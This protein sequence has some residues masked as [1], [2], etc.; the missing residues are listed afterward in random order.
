MTDTQADGGARDVPSRFSVDFAGQTLLSTYRVERKLAE[1][2][3]GTVYLGEDTNLGRQVV[4]KVPHARFLGEPGFRAR[5]KREVTELV[6][7]EHPNICRILAQGDNEELPYF[8]L[9]YLGGGSL[10]ERLKAAGGSVS[11]HDALPWLRTIAKTLDFIHARGIIHRDVKP[12]NV[13]LSKFGEVKL[14]DFGIARTQQSDLTETGIGLGT[15]SY[16]SPEQI[17]G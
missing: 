4:V 1:G 7:L 5:F 17:V 11:S 15:P 8:V 3:M 13:I 2:G 9:Q 14:T 6:R 16:M 10:E 12:A